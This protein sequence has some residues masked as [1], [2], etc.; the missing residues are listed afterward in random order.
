[1]NHLNSTQKEV[2]RE[3][4]NNISNTNNLKEFINNKF[5]GLKKELKSQIR[6]VTDKT[7]MIKLAEVINLIKPI[8]KNE[9]VK[10]D[11][12]LNLLQ[13]SQL[14]EELKSLSK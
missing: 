7:T 13:Y 8:E 6:G 5:V 3:Y 14:T 12:I 2:L 9:N 1:M 4:I 11:D 10:D